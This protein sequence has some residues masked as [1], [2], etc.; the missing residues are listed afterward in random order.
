MRSPLLLALALCGTM[1]AVVAQS[2]GTAPRFRTPGVQRSAAPRNEDGGLLL[3]NDWQ[4]VW[5]G[6]VDGTLEYAESNDS[7]LDGLDLELR[8]IELNGAVTIDANA[9]AYAAVAYQDEEF[10]LFEAAVVYDGLPGNSSLKLGRYFVDFGKQ[11]Q[12]HRHELRTLERPLVLR[13]F[14]G[15]SSFGDG[16]QYD[17]WFAAGDRTAVR[18]SLS[19][20]GQLRAQG[21]ESRDPFVRPFEEDRRDV[22]ELALTARVTGYADLTPVSQVQVGASY[23]LVPD[24]T[25]DFDPSGAQVTGLNNGTL[26]L[27]ATFAWID[28]TFGRQWTTGGEILWF[29]GDVGAIVDD[30]GTPTDFSDDTFTVLEDSVIGFYGFFDYSW[31]PDHSGGLQ[32]SWVELPQAG[33][34]EAGELDLY[35]TRHL[36]DHHRLRFGLSLLH[37][38]MADEA[39]RLAIQYTGLIGSHT[40]GA[41]W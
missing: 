9:W 35:Y 34:P 4:A 19:L 29:N 13:E 27:D 15:T 31:D 22:E 7:E 32:Y 10:D 17:N 36:G 12:F 28:P 14:L 2:R 23:R 8:T 16:I 39:V 11:M 1:P 5:A 41:N 21:D 30:T 37:N 26:G 20:F 33:K 38:D 40:H 6:V 24:F 18:Y 3:S 25:F